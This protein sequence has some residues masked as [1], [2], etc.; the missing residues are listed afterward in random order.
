MALCTK[1][2]LRF[3]IFHIRYIQSSFLEFLHANQLLDGTRRATKNKAREIYKAIHI[4]LLINKKTDWY[5]FTVL[6]CYES[7]NS[8]KI[9]NNFLNFFVLNKLA[10]H[11]IKN[12]FIAVNLAP[13]L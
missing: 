6:I 12:F 3:R 1:I 8:R 5:R 11:E 13:S 9:I 7:K 4:F 2:T 10:I